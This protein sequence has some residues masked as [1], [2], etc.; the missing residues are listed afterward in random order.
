MGA[1]HSFFRNHNTLG[2]PAQDPAIWPSVAAAT[3]TANLFRYQYLPYLFSLHFQASKDGVTV[4]RPLFFEFPTD[5]EV[6]DLGYQFMWGPSVLVAP[7]VYEGA[8]STSLYLPN[9]VW[10]SLFDYMYGSKIAPGYITVPSPTTSRI[11][12]FVRGWLY[13]W[14]IP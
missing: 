10:Y 11:P 14:Y 3:K 1:F 13:C 4:I 5:S 2:S 12:V 6:I 9:D 8:S 7:V